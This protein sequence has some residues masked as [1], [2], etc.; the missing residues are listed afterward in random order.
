MSLFY[1]KYLFG[2]TLPFIIIYSMML[3][4]IYTYIPVVYIF[5]LLPILEIII[6]PDNKNL[7]TEQEKNVSDS[8]FFDLLTYL[9]VPLQFLSIYYFLEVLLNVRLDLYELIGMILSLGISCGVLGINVGHELGHRKKLS[10]Q[11]FANMLLCSS[12]YMHFFIEH[13]KGHHKHVATPMDPASAVKGQNLYSFWWQSIKG[14]YV[15]AW[16][17]QMIDL[18]K[19]SSN[20][21]SLYNLMFY[22]HIIQGFFLYLIYSYYGIENVFYFVCAAMIGILLLETVNYIEHYGLSRTLTKKGYSKIL[23]SHSW[24]S[25]HPLGRLV[26]FELSRHSD[27]HYQASRK[28]QILRHFD[29][30]LQMPYGYPAMIIIATVPPLW[31]KIMDP[32]LNK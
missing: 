6:S 19:N 8:F 14:S 27:H 26:M 23:P 24:N 32:H 12:L 7:T 13:N 1:I 17:I 9:I 21:F 22:L 29:D 3:K 28:Y 10:E 5:V 4:G 16:K 20:F 25:N 2:I 18:K 11:I 30:A 15:S 31:F